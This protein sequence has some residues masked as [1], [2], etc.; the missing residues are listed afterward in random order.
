MVGALPAHVEAVFAESWPPRGPE[1]VKIARVHPALVAQLKSALVV[2]DRIRVAQL[3]SG[4]LVAVDCAERQTTLARPAVEREKTP[5]PLV[6]NASD[7]WIVV[8]LVRPPLRPGL[9]DRFLVAAAAGGLKPRLLATK[10]DLA[11]EP[12]AVAWLA[13]YERL[14]FDVLRTSVVTGAGLQDLRTRLAGAFSVLVGQSGVG[15]SSVIRA[16]LPERPIAVAELSQATGKGRHTT[17][18]T[19]TYALPEG[20][21]VVDT[22]GLRELGLWGAERAHLNR[23]FPDVA[24]LAT[25]CRFDDCRHGREPGC[26]VH[27]SPEL[28]V[29]RLQ[30]WR[31]LSTEI[32]ERLRPG[33]GKPGGPGGR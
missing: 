33:F 24:A 28:P 15:K 6:A 22:P 18:V 20:G 5:Q 29:E 10:T 4:Q 3:P 7:L 17:T 9:V 27:G 14:G 19:R 23:A 2:G 26:A 12:E 13:L 1:D 21:A 31:K 11:A 8:S 30:S 25:G 32:D 16:I